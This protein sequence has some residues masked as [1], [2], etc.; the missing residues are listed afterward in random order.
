MK[1]LLISLLC[2]LWFNLG[3]AQIQ[4]TDS[5]YNIWSQTGKIAIA[6]DYLYLQ[7]ETGIQILKY[8]DITTPVRLTTVTAK[9]SVDYTRNRTGF[10]VSGN[11]LFSGFVNGDLKTGGIEIF[12]I[13]GS[14]FLIKVGE[15][16]PEHGWIGNFILKDDYLVCT[17]Y[18]NDPVFGDKCW[19]VSYNITDVTTPAYAFSEEIG[20]NGALSTYQKDNYIFLK[21][22]VGTFP[23]MTTSF[24]LYS[25]ANP[26]MPFE[27]GEINYFPQIQTNHPNIKSDL[28][29]EDTLYTVTY[30][31]NYLYGLDISNPIQPDTF[32]IK[33]IS[34]YTFGGKDFGLLEK[35][36]SEIITF[37]KTDNGYKLI[38]FDNSVITQMVETDSY[39]IPDGNIGSAIFKNDTLLYSQDSARIVSV[40]VKS[41]D[42]ASGSFLIN[43]EYNLPQIAQ[44]TLSGSNA[45]ASHFSNTSPYNRFSVIDIS[46]NSN[47]TEK[48]FTIADNSYSTQSYTCALYND[49]MTV[50]YDQNN[51][52]LYTLAKSG[53]LNEEATIINQ[54]FKALAI[55]G[56]YIIAGC[57]N[58]KIKIYDVSDISLPIPVYQFPADYNT[59]TLVIDTVNNLLY[60]IEPNGWTSYLEVWD[61]SAITSPVLSSEYSLPEKSDYINYLHHANGNFFVY[62]HQGATDFF[63]AYELSGNELTESDRLTF[64]GYSHPGFN[65]NYAF[66][67]DESGIYVISFQ[68]PGDL[69]QAFFLPDN[70]DIIDLAANNNTL[71]V[72]HAN[73]VD[74]YDLSTIPLPPGVFDLLS[75]QGTLTSTDTVLIWEASIDPNGNAPKYEVW[76]A[77][78]EAFTD[79]VIDTTA[80]TFYRIEN[81]LPEQNIFWKVAAIDEFTE[82]VESNQVFQ[83][84]LDAIE[85]TDLS[86]S[87]N[88]DEATLS[89]S[90]T[91]VPAD[92][93]IVYQ[94]LLGNTTD[95]TNADTLTSY[96]KSIIVADLMPGQ[97][98]YWK[99][100]AGNSQYFSSW[101]TYGNYFNNNIPTPNL[102]YAKSLGSN[103]ESGVSMLDP[104]TLYA[105]A[106]AS[107]NRYSGNGD[108]DYTLQVNG[109]IKSSTTVTPDHRVYIAS[110]DNNLYAFN[111]NGVS[112][113]GWPVALGAQLE[114]SVTVD[115]NHN[116]Y[117]GT[118]NGIYQ[119][120]SATGEVLWSYN[121]GSSVKAS[122]AITN[123]DTLYVINSNGR[124]FAFDL[125]NINI[126]NPQPLWTLETN[127]TISNSP[128]I[129]DN[130]I[131]V[132]SDDGYLLKVNNNGNS[133]DL[134]IEVPT[135]GK[136]FSSPVIDGNNNVYFAADSGLVYSFNAETGALNWKS[137]TYYTKSAPTPIYSTGTLSEDGY[138]YIGDSKGVLYGFDVSNGEIA[139]SYRGE[140]IPIKGSI[141]YFQNWVFY[142]NGNKFICLQI[143][144]LKS[145]S[146]KS[147]SN[148][149]WGTFQGNNMRTGNKDVISS[150]PARIDKIESS[151]IEIYPNPVTNNQLYINLKNNESNE[152]T[153]QILTISGTILKK[154]KVNRNGSHSIEFN[155]PAGMYLIK[156]NQNEHFFSYPIIN[157]GQ[158]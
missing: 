2:I 140:S 119:C 76:I 126:N 105:A 151:N 43:D 90:E 98:Y 149:A 31:P 74:I 42:H 81:L 49:L 64:S 15:I 10:E 97:H 19:L 92:M 99:V 77:D 69:Q 108:L 103:S 141:A 4:K 109:M 44:I 101:Q 73:K 39:G 75:P 58:N 30:S 26:T 48:D 125:N 13:Q 9:G 129:F 146:L 152:V 116:L 32:L 20:S 61:I 134:A 150:A 52:K 107:V 41:L 65:E 154:L 110:T 88:D 131:I 35:N 85:L 137:E 135:N 87:V 33:D 158:D 124:V 11:Y 130:S 83:C 62:S 5:I 56:N 36:G 25:I 100:R 95:F 54:D 34:T 104:N 45:I 84:S 8:S 132:S 68:Y 70:F 78:N 156:I 18:K 94:V 14:G 24:H 147:G 139:C 23:M 66:V 127:H 53:Q 59:E 46:N 91:G 80:E 22:I 16:E 96:A 144:S 113:S 128:A 6:D 138:L 133:G 29:N 123:Q 37:Q 51:T 143:P 145:F 1:E 67:A 115:D 7:S 71:M 112:V 72:A 86:V 157:K 117:L 55:S 57:T 118:S 102:V 89:W 136:S 122:S 111:Q 3:F 82:N 21:K 114:A 17:E 120:V 106:A 121:V 12:E 50:R 38:T 63:F 40:A 93:P 79:A 142:T 153:I 27:V 47:I 155:Y 60:L 28:V 148:L